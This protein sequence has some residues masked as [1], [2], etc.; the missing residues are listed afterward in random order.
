MYSA[1]TVLS[2]ISVCNL[3]VPKLVDIHSVTEHNQFLTWHKQNHSHSQ[4]SKVQQSLHPHNN[5][6]PVMHLAWR[7]A[8]CLVFPWGKDEFGGMPAH[9]FSWI[10]GESCTLMHSKLDVWLTVQSQI[11]QDSDHWSIAPWQLTSW[12]ISISTKWYSTCWG[13]LGITLL[14]SSSF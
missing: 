3:E 11:H 7:Q 8:P 12:S 14:H 5:L 9:N 2:A 6:V 13:R 1:S 4:P 10:T